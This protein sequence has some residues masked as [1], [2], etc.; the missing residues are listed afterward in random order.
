MGLFI[1]RKWYYRLLSGAMAGML[2]WLLAEI[3][4]TIRYRYFDLFADPVNYLYA[5]VYGILVL[6]TIYRAW[7]WIDRNHYRDS[8]PGRRFILQALTG[9]LIAG[10]WLFGFRLL[11]SFLV[12]PG[13]LIILSNELLILFVVIFLVLTLDFMDLGHFLIERY[14]MS[15]AEVEKFRKENAEYQ[16]EMLKLQL[17]PHFLFNS[18]NTLSSLVHEDQAK[19]AEFIRKLSD[20]YRYV[21]DNRSRELVSLREEMEFI[22]SFTFLQGL[23]FQGMIDF[24]YKIDDLTLDRK[25]AP[26]TLQLLVENAVKHNIASRKMPLYIEI[27]SAGNELVVIN[28]LQ[29]KEEQKGTGVGLKNIT[30]RYEFLSGRKV[31]IMNDHKVFKVIIP[32]I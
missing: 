3:G 8:S 19:S 11:I 13:K 25:I 4:L 18:L 27:V 32:L 9:I 2:T 17:N 29:P 20:V 16:F 31:Q 10:F 21:L 26:M 22:R 1:F 14:R 23:R 6:E 30:S 15:L 7:R 12:S 24:I 5:V 28:N